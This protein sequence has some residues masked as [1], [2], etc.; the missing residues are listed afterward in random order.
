MTQRFVP[1]AGKS[2]I[3][4]GLPSGPITYLAL[5]RRGSVMNK[6]THSTDQLRGESYSPPLKIYLS[7]TLQLGKYCLNG[8]RTPCRWRP[9][10]TN[11]LTRGAAY[12]LT[13]HG[14]DKARP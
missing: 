11:V 3:V 4:N 12:L 1:G 5:G 2:A 9:N 7:T 6:L 13:H 8:R 14:R 10:V